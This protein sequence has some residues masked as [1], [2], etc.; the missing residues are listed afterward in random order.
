MRHG[1]R[2][3]RAESRRPRDG[4]K[5]HAWEEWSVNRDVAKYVNLA[6][7]ALHAGQEPALSAGTLLEQFDCPI[8]LWAAPARCRGDVRSF[9]SLALNEWM[10]K[11]VGKV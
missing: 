3:R 11:Y 7:A 5:G 1:E 9:V 8:L 10:A 4:K 6:W 2:D